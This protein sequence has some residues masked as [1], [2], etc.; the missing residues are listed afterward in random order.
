MD[1]EGIIPNAVLPNYC[2]RMQ[3]RIPK[4]MLSHAVSRLYI[5]N[6]HCT[7]RF[8]ILAH[9]IAPLLIQVRITPQPSHHIFPIYRLTLSS[10]PSTRRLTS[11]PHL[12]P[13]FQPFLSLQDSTL[14]PTLAPIPHPPAK[15]MIR[16]GIT[17]PSVL[18]RLWGRRDEWRRR[19]PLVLAVVVSMTTARIAVVSA[20]GRRRAGRRVRG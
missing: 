13:F 5:V 1:F 16:L 3:T 7:T 10:P 20:G 4:P 8:L 15:R 19:C 11:F 9:V 17:P 18:L 2:T 14:A 6:S 12:P